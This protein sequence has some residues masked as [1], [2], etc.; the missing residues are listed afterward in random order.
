MQGGVYLGYI[1][2]KWNEVHK[3]V[4]KRLDVNKDGCG[5]SVF[6][7]YGGNL[8]T[9]SLLCLRSYEAFILMLMSCS[10]QEI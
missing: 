5:F 9:A 3:E 4:I 1:E 7:C 6:P 10:C 2:V 8:L